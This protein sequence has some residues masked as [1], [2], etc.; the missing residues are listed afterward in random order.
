MDIPVFTVVGINEKTG[1]QN[2]FRNIEALDDVQAV[3]KAVAKALESNKI[4]IEPF[5]VTRVSPTAATPRQIEYAKD[6]GIPIP[7]NA[8]LPT[9]SRLIS[10]AVDDEI[11]FSN[12]C[13]TSCVT[14][15]GW[16]QWPASL[17]DSSEQQDR[18]LRARSAQ[19][20]PLGISHKNK[21][22]VISS[23]EEQR[24]YL[25]SLGDCQ[26]PDFVIR[27][28]PCKH[29]YRLAYEL[30]EYVLIDRLNTSQ[31]GFP[32]PSAS[33][34]NAT[35]PMPKQ[36]WIVHVLLAVLTA[37]VGNIVYGLYVSHK[38]REWSQQHQQP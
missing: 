11:D 17:H 10:Y 32:N 33:T 35:P 12:A 25:T 6:L 7:M 5:I 8:T 13:V 38:K 4:L 9:M 34:S 22:A 19:C 37:G 20:I 27:G 1:K 28:L 24:T 36:N 3:E 2:T 16:Q 14:G 30:D 18:Q 29:M 21:L 23:A 31:V 26:C 15:T